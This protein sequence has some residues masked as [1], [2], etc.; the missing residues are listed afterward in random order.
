MATALTFGSGMINN[1]E[2][3]V[4]QHSVRV[5]AVSD[6]ATVFLV[7]DEQG[8]PRLDGRVT[9]LRQLVQLIIVIVEA[10]VQGFGKITGDFGLGRLIAFGLLIMD[11]ERVSLAG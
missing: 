2:C 10:I 5:R 3:L 9:Q 8:L 6:E 11:T 7:D 4:M 1:G